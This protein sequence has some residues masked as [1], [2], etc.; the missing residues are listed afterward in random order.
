MRVLDRQAGNQPF[1]ACCRRYVR[2]SHLIPPPQSSGLSD[3]GGGFHGRKTS[4]TASGVQ[5]DEFFW[6]CRRLL[7]WICDGFS[8]TSLHERLEFKINYRAS[9]EADQFISFQVTRGSTPD[10]GVVFQDCSLGSNMGVTLTNVYNGTFIDTTPG[11]NEVTYTLHYKL[12]C[13]STD[14]I[15]T[16]FGILGGTNNR[17]YIFLQELYVP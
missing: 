7:T 3:C 11:G 13:P 10:T 6:G 1:S 12:D 15:D 16:A 2:T 8:R 17:N 9:P 4:H 5:H 14:T